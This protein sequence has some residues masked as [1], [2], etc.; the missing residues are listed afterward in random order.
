MFGF[1]TDIKNRLVAL[2]QKIEVIWNHMFHRVEVAE[3]DVTDVVNPNVGAAQTASV[4]Q[5]SSDGNATK[6]AENGTGDTT[7]ATQEGK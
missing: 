6:P 3:Q 2:E 4:Q 5:E 7:D 1:F